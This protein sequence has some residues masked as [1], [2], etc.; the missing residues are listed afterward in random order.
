MTSSG[1]KYKN[2]VVSALSNLLPPKSV[3]INEVNIDSINFEAPKRRKTSIKTLARAFET[4]FKKKEWFVTGVVDPSFFSNDFTFQDPDVK[5]DGLRGYAEGVRK[6]F[7]QRTSRAEIIRV[8]NQG[9]SKLVVTW[10][11]SGR[12]NLGPVGLAIKP[13]VVY[14]D[15]LLGPDGLIYRQEDRFSLPAYDIF[16]S[17]FLPFLSG[18]VLAPPAAPADE[19]REKL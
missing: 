7:D 16:L 19:L 3:V 4:A 11:L 5:L 8:G 13:Y 2:I 1:P 14:T 10:R 12:V 17:A 18:R 15:L 6:L 9:D